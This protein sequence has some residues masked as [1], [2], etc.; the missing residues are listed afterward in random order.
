ML[1]KHVVHGIAVALF[2]SVSI[3]ACASNTPGE[4]AVQAGGSEPEPTDQQ[5]AGG[6][7]YD[8]VRF[9][10]A[11]VNEESARKYVLQYLE[12]FGAPEGT[13]IRELLAGATSSNGAL[14]AYRTLND[15]AGVAVDD[16]DWPESGTFDVLLATV[17]DGVLSPPRPRYGVESGPARG[18]ALLFLIHESGYQVRMIVD[19]STASTAI[20]GD[21]DF[22]RGFSG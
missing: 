2:L 5:P 1:N 6:K 21:G 4:I 18:D 22:K 16:A 19:S 20:E 14:E 17:G 10:E 13:G 7:E 15:V 12:Y 3:A 9:D 8:P 11:A